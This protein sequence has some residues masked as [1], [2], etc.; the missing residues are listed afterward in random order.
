M[1]RVQCYPQFQVPTGGIRTY[2]PQIRGEL[3]YIKY[4]FKIIVQS[5][6]EFENVQLKTAIPSPECL[7]Y[8]HYE[9]IYFQYYRLC[10]HCTQKPLQL[11]NKSLGRLT[12]V[13]NGSPLT[14][15]CRSTGL[16]LFFHCIWKDRLCPDFSNAHDTLFSNTWILS[17]IWSLEVFGL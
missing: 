14:K 2:L 16:F 1:Y 5:W 9:N 10:N 4:A 3:L 7:F 15:T 17:C 13:I 6:I 12:G 11:K 8:I